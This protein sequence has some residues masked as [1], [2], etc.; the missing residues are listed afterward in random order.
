MLEGQGGFAGGNIGVSAGE[1][2]ILIVDD[3]LSKMSDTMAAS[4][5]K[6][7]AGKLRFI[8]NTHWHGDHTG[9]NA[10][11]TKKDESTII[12]HTNV[13]K[14]LMVAQENSFGKSPAQPP[15]AW[16]LI[17]FDKT[18]TI[19]FNGEDIRFMHYPNGHTDGDGIV[20][21]NRSN[22]AHLGDH[23]FAGTFPYVDLATGGN[24][25][26]LTK[27]IQDIIS[28]LPDDAI[29]IPGH[30]ALSDVKGLKSYRDMLVA[31]TSFVKAKADK[32][33]D[34]EDI[35]LDGLPKEWAMWG[36][37]FVNEQDWIAL[38]YNSL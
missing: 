19:H 8:L 1:D 23:Y 2:G 17:T 16:P 14:R 30:G 29:I 36:G 27:N 11:F 10:H 37:G 15:S 3:L 25:F 13:R 6:I 26:G 20:Y 9:G 7:N 32:G 5:A 24:A 22:V 12:A 18:L 31:T 4:L 21:F 33:E 35:Q 34:L 38:I 28:A